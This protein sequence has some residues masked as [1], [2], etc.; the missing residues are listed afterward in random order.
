M[1]LQQNLEL[2]EERN[3]SMMFFLPLDVPMHLGQHRL[4]HRE[5]AI[6]F[7]PF[8]SAASLNVREIQPD[9]F[10]FS[11]PMSFEIALSC[12]SFARM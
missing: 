3:A 4:T 9:E 6:S 1:R 8:E 11:S 12:R 7:L 5:R 2:L 10:A